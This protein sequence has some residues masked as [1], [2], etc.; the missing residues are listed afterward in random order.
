KKS[1]AATKFLQSH[2]YAPA[3]AVKPG[4][5]FMRSPPLRVGTY[6]LAL[7]LE[8]EFSIFARPPPG[9]SPPPPPS[10]LAPPPH[11]RPASRPLS[12]TMHSQPPRLQLCNKSA[13]AKH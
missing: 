2:S 10:W 3:R 5:A 8:H 7:A 6:C 13:L 12:L 4:Q 9:G 1:D 11:A